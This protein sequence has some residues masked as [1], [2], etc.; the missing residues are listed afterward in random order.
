MEA[1][2]MKLISEEK[3]ILIQEYIND[4]KLK[5]SITLEDIFTLED[6]IKYYNDYQ[7]QMRNDVN[8]KL[9]ALLAKEAHYDYIISEDLT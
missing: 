5:F 3:D 4:V 1:Y 6:I 2:N 8:N 9:K 7:I